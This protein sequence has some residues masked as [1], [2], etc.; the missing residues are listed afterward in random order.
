MLLFTDTAWRRQIGLA[1][2]SRRTAG[3]ARG[4]G[5]DSAREMIENMLS[6]GWVSSLVVSAE[7]FV[8]RLLMTRSRSR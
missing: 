5:I 2:M 1:M 7:K 4:R 6:S 3:E 8:K